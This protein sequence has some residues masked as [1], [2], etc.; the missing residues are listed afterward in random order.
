MKRRSKGQAISIDFMLAMIIMLI[1]IGMASSSWDRIMYIMNEKTQ[2]TELKRL[3]LAVSDM[4]VRNPGTPSDWNGSSVLS[5]GLVDKHNVLN[6]NKI[7]SFLGMSK[8]E[9]QNKLGIQGY[10]FSFRVRAVNGTVIADYVS[11]PSN[12]TNVIIVRR[13]AVYETIPVHI[14]FGLWRE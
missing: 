3:G 7:Q 4:L 2:R 5:I 10:G 9:I 14:E 11:T 8:N 13:I 6:K 12:P 1:I